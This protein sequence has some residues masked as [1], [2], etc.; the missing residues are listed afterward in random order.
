MTRRTSSCSRRPF[1]RPTFR[2]SP[3]AVASRAVDAAAVDARAFFLMG[4][5]SRCGNTVWGEKARQTRQAPIL[6]VPRQ[7]DQVHTRRTEHGVCKLN[8]K[9]KEEEGRGRKGPSERKEVAT[10]AIIRNRYLIFAYLVRFC[11]GSRFRVR[12]A[13]LGDI[14]VA[15]ASTDSPPHAYAPDWVVDGHSG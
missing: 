6:S 14:G 9:R 10:R 11:S 15:A 3:A 8:E 5:G 13:T 1:M 12:S 2:G 4:R 7:F